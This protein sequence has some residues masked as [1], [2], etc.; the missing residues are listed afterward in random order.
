MIRRPAVAGQ[1]YPADPQSL[2]KQLVELTRG[3]RPPE[4]PRAI[5]L[6]V[7]HA[8]YV[9]SGRIAAETYTAARLARRAVILCPNHTGQGEAIAAIDEGEWDTPLGR[10]PVDT[11]LA[12]E[13]LAGCRR[14]RVDWTAHAREHSLEVQLPFLQLLLEDVTFAPICVGTLDLEVLLELGRAVAA[15][16]DSGHD[17]VMLI[18]SSDMSHYV[19]A[20]IASRQDR[21]AIDRVL[22]LDPEGL[23]RTVL[24][25]DISMCGV[26][27]TVA[28]LEAAC[29][30]G[31]GAARLVA[32]GN[33]GETTGDLR[34]VVGY[35]GVAVT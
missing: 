24:E 11:R 15:A 10:V 18:M 35:A 29:R 2:R 3:R 19:P 33:S 30:I 17:D 12:R 23:H 28:G 5:A 27:P 20:A 8:G 26:A 25:E 32:Y 7:P 34:S 13:I 6:M 22:A 9:Y 4:E 16:I 31:A 14:A 21:R 1:F